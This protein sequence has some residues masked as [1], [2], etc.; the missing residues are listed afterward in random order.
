MVLSLFWNILT[1][2]FKGI[3]I[4]KYPAFWGEGKYMFQE[5]GNSGISDFDI[6]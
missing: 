1:L 3:S 6:I 4:W 5:A 2:S